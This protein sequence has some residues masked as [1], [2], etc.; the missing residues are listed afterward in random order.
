MMILLDLG[1]LSCLSGVF[2][3]VNSF[4]QYV[5]SKLDDPDLVCTTYLFRSSWTVSLFTFS[6]GIELFIVRGTGDWIFCSFS[7]Y[8]LFSFSVI[9]SWGL[10]WGVNWEMT[11]F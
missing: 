5:G 10:S 1:W 7:F 6:R 4:S 2:F 9:F 8:C 11:L 3:L